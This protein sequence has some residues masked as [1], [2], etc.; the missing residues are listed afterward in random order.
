MFGNEAKK[1]VRPVVVQTQGQH[2]VVDLAFHA[3][4]FATIGLDHQRN[5][6]ALNQLQIECAD[7]THFTKG[8]RHRSSLADPFVRRRASCPCNR[9]RADHLDHPSLPIFH[10]RC[11]VFR[12][13]R[14]FRKAAA[15]FQRAATGC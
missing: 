13:W 6:L 3:R 15:A 1:A 7:Q 5:R 14:H 4:Q 2:A 10:V 9:A 8:L 12:S 11:S